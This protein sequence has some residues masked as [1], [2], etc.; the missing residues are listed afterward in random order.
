M[1]ERPNQ[2]Q[3]RIITPEIMAEQIALPQEEWSD[4]FRQ[5]IAEE[6]QKELQRRNEETPEKTIEEER[7][8][9][10]ERYLHG[11]ALSPDELKDKVI[12]DIGSGD[13][14]FVEELTDRGITQEAYGIDVKDPYE[15]EKYSKHFFKDTFEKPLPVKDA[16]YA[17]SVGAISNFAGYAETEDALKEVLKNALAAI[18]ENG[19]VRIYPIQHASPG[20]KLEGID[21]SYKRWQELM[22]KLAAE[23]NLDWELQPIGIHIAGNNLDNIWL[24]E[25]LKFKK[26]KA[27][28]P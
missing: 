18:K 21:D 25:M 7:R 15:A 3:E 19:E 26:R 22:T 11:L 6:T 24:E 8:A 16:D 5:Y 12:M 4:E 1:F 14:E 20:S 23:D 10:F 17:L 27:Q 2:N 28:Q 9:T 13:G